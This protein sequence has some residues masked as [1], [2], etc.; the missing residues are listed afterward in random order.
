MANMMKM[1]KQAQEIAKHRMVKK[2][3]PLALGDSYKGF[4]IVGTNHGETVGS[5][6]DNLRA[7]QELLQSVE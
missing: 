5:S 4:R 6:G 1:L 7:S 3:I 2:T